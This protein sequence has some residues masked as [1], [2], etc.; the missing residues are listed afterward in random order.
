VGKFP[1][2]IRSMIFVMK[3]RIMTGHE[4]LNCLSAA[5]SARRTSALPS[6]Q[7]VREELKLNG[8]VC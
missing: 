7:D 6:E 5:D 1:T 3:F 8:K 4:Q 2:R